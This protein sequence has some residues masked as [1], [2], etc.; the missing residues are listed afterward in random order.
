FLLCVLRTYVVQINIFVKPSP[1]LL[2]VPCTY[3]VLIN[4]FAEPSFFLSD[5]MPGGR[6]I[7]HVGFAVMKE[8]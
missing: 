4:I 6:N 2:C 8:K 7:A 3:L 1:F 5:N